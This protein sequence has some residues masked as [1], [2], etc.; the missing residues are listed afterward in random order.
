MMISMGSQ[1]SAAV[2]AVQLPEP[3]EAAMDVHIVDQEVYQTID[4]NADADKQQP[5]VSSGQAND[6]GKSRW[7]GKDQ[8]E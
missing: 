5:K 3:L 2:R 6:I 7:N 4:G 1:N 8:E